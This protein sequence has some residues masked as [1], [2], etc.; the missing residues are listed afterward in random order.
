[1]RRIGYLIRQWNGH[2]FG[3]FVGQLEGHSDWKMRALMGGR[4]I[5]NWTVKEWECIHISEDRH[6]LT[7]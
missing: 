3:T 1:M 6:W 4:M 7:C 2:E 5:L